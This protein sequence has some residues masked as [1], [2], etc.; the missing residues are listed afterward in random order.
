MPGLVE[1]H[2]LIFILYAGLNKGLQNTNI[3]IALDSSALLNTC[4]SVHKP[5]LEEDPQLADIMQRLPKIK[6][7]YLSRKFNT[8][9]DRL[10]G[11]GKCRDIMRVSWL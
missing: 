2:A 4:N 9:A 7:A 6:V 1:K 8:E 5:L 3:L 10:A 11:E